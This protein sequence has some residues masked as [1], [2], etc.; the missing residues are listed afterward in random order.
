MILEIIAVNHG[1][2]ASVPE[3][4]KKEGPHDVSYQGRIFEWGGVVDTI[5]DTRYPKVAVILTLTLWK[6]EE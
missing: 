4:V 1:I 5:G 2:R 3:K 6:L